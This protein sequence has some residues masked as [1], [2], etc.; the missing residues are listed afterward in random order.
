MIPNGRFKPYHSI[1]ITSSRRQTAKQEFISEVT[2]LGRA[3]TKTFLHM[4]LMGANPIG[5]K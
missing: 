2:V 5:F 4:P 3:L 1:Y